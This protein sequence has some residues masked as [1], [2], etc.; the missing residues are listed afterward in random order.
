MTENP[1]GLSENTL[2]L[3][4]KELLSQYSFDYE[5]EES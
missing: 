2:D 4:V 3:T 1:K 5:W